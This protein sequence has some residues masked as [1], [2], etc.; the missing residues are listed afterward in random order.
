MTKLPKSN[1][2]R[3]KKLVKKVKILFPFPEGTLWERPG[4]IISA[5]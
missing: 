4:L 1:E 2:E 5:T 3:K